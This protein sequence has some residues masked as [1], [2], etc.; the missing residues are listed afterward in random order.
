MKVPN[1]A[2]SNQTLQQSALRAAA[3]RRNVGRRKTPIEE[4]NLKAEV[5]SISYL[6]EGG[7]EGK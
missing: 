5:G 3:E 4:G 7:H 6:W 2:M 1:W